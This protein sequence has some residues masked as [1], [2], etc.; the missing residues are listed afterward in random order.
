VEADAVFRGGLIRK[1]KQ[2][3]QYQL[4]KNPDYFSECQHGDGVLINRR[5]AA[6]RLEIRIG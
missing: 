3:G 2:A 4:P 1:E 5:G 6:F